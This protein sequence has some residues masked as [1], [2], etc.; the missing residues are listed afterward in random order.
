VNEDS[1]D[2][3]PAGWESA[4]LTALCQINPSLDRCIVNDAIEVNFVPMRA[5]ESEGAGLVRP[6]VRPY[7]R[8]KRGYTSFLSG[9]VIMAKITPC[10]ENGKTTVVPDLPGSVCFG[11]T[12]FH[13]IRPETGVLAR[14][15]ANFLVQHE[16]RRSA[17]RAMTGGVGQMRVPAAFLQSLRVP[18]APT[19]EQE[20]IADV[21]DELLSDLD[22]G[23]AALGRVR[24]KLKLYRAAVLKAAVEG[25]LT[26]A[27]RKERPQTEPASELLKRILVERRRRWEEEQLRKFKEKAREP[28]KNWKAKYREPVAPDAAKLPLLPDSWCWATVEQLASGRNGSIQSGPFGSQLLHSEFKKEGPLAIGIDNVLDGKFSLGSQHRISSAKFNALSKFEARPLDV[29]V[30]VMATVGRV[31]VLPGDLETSIITKHCYRITTAE[32]MVI[33]AYLA[34]ALRAEGATRLYIFGNIRGQ[35]RPGI[36]GPILKRAPVALPPTAEQEAIVEAI[37]GQ[38]SVVDHLE[39]DLD[40]KVT[41]AQALRQ[42][43]LRHAFSGKLVPQN[44]KEEPASELLKRI[45]A[46]RE[47][48]AREATEAKRLNGH[49]TRHAGKLHGKTPRGRA[50]SKK[51][52]RH[53]RIADR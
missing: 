53:G 45:A 44:R 36:N 10:M 9:D 43:I 3:L 5:V 4:S 27:W 39:A 38:L 41:N 21:L 47:Q 50:T 42:S 24:D 14:W 15:I 46:E 20:R 32:Q 35:T 25:A 52:T 28:P 7:R 19:K 16:V 40:A 26:D 31:C 1:T 48:R 6:E 49:P 8:V 17:Q 2:S 30:T 34:T 33:P 23:L 13:V 11:S 12:E 18:I 37:E 22:A 29:V 51:E